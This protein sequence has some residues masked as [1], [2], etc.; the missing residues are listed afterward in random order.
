MPSFDFFSFISQIFWLALTCFCFYLITLKI[1]AKIAEVKK[2]RAKLK[3]LK[4]KKH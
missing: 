2:F 4:N 1:L 3:N